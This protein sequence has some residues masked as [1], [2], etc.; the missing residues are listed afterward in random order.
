MAES[1]VLTYTGNAAGSGASIGQGLNATFNNAFYITWR[2]LMKSI[3]P[4][5]VPY[6]ATDPGRPSLPTWMWSQKL[7]SLV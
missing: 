2:S 5:P 3:V 7:S 1:T 4:N 6:N